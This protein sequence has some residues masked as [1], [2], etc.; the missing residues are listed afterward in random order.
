[1]KVRP[2]EQ[3]EYTA[4]MSGS[5]GYVSDIPVFKPTWDEF[6]NFEKFI[7]SIEDKGKDFGI[8]KVIPPKE[9][10]PRA[11]GY[12]F[13]N[14]GYVGKKIRTKRKSKCEDPI[15]IHNPVAQHVNGS[16]G[17]YEVIA[18]EKSEYV[19][20]HEFAKACEDRLKKCSK[21]EQAYFQEK[22][23]RE[24]ERVYWRNISTRSPPTYG[25]DSP[26][27][28]FDKDLE[29]WNCKNLGTILDLIKNDLPGVTVPMLYFG[30]WQATF[31]WHVED[32]NLFSI[33]YLHFGQPKQWYSIPGSHFEQTE[34]LFKGLYPHQVRNCT[35][36]LRHKKCLV[37]PNL[38]KGHGLPVHRTVQEEGEFIITFP[39]AFHAGF[40]YG[41]N[42]AESVNFA[43]RS[44][45]TD[46]CKANFCRCVSDSVKIDM[47]DFVSRMAK[48]QLIKENDSLFEE[49]RKAHE[50]RSCVKPNKRVT[51]WSCPRCTYLNLRA[52]KKCKICQHRPN[53][54]EMKVAIRSAQ[55]L[56]ED[57]VQHAKRS[58]D[59]HESQRRSSNVPESSLH[60]MDD[61]DFEI[62]EGVQ[63]QE[64]SL[65][66]ID[67]TRE[68]CSEVR[69]VPSTSKRRRLQEPEKIFEKKCQF[70]DHEITKFFAEIRIDS[71]YAE[72]VIRRK[73][74]LDELLKMGREELKRILPLGP[75]MR[76]CNHVMGRNEKQRCASRLSSE[77]SQRQV[78]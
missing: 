29:N 72:K 77:R 10:V 64:P 59:A 17:I 18:V 5:E 50:K 19:T 20:V 7:A 28:L 25:A 38:L 57:T 12:Y 32:M 33:N 16:R 14:L 73:I 4:C 39:K 58:R 52:P 27:T 45:V 31:S 11:D 15:I 66:L 35:E 71:H 1:M 9:Y 34:R 44:W 43:M 76:L 60:F 36:F 2:Q 47:V 48:N 56:R 54:A 55:A 75:R 40:N 3:V 62:E 78:C 21:R 26:G 49:A 61:D 41:F 74:K 37:T 8:V 24:L 23:F 69:L 65:S 68:D 6:K 30:M 42:C 53:K 22:N 67:L 70:P 46:G 13:E 51:P 63:T